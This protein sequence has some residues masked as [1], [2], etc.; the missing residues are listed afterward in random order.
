MTALHEL[1]LRKTLTANDLGRTGSH[2]AGIHIPKQLVPYMPAL[3]ERARNPDCTIEVLCGGKSWAWRYIHYNGE[4]FGDG[5]RDEYRVLR[6]AAFL[7]E[8]RPAPGDIL[9]LVLTGER[10]MRAAIRAEI[11]G[12]GLLVL[13]TRGPWRVVRVTRGAGK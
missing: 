2:Q 6:V 9:E 12:D 1:V 7:T 8:T 4:L 13:E 3:D 10:R 11:E 5:T